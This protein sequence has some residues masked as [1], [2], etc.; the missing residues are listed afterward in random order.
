MEK[1]ACKINFEIKSQSPA[2]A[3][4]IEGFANKAI[5]DRGMDLIPPEAWEL[6]EFKNN[7]ILLFNHNQDLAIGT[8]DVKVTDNGLYAKAKISKSNEAPLPYIRDMIKEGIIKSFSVGFDSKNSEE[9]SEDGT[10]TVLKRANLLELSVVTVPMN[11][12]S[13]FMVSNKCVS[14][15]KS[16]SYHEA[17]SDML[18]FKGAFLAQA[19]HDQIAHLQEEKSDFD[20]DEVID[21]ILEQSG[22]SEKKLDEILAGNSKEIS[23][24][25][26]DAIAENLD[27]DPNQ[28]RSLDNGDSERKEAEGTEEKSEAESDKNHEQSE[29][30]SCDEDEDKEKMKEEEDE[31]KEKMMD[32][33]DKEDEEK[34]EHEDE[35]DEEKEKSFQE[36]VSDKI[37]KLIA[38]GKTQDQAIA[39]AISMC[40]DLEKSYEVTKKD[41]IEFMDVAKNAIPEKKNEEP[42]VN[43]D[44][45]SDMVEN[46][47]VSNP[48]MDQFKAQT[49]LMAQQNGLLQDL[50]NEVRALRSD[51]QNEKSEP[52]TVAMTEENPDEKESA[53]LDAKKERMSQYMQKLQELENLI[54]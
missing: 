27:L 1:K 4:T 8:A 2:R 46:A 38:E 7:N 13:T 20:R 29:K 34:M 53:E 16:K 42:T 41:Y 14:S 22:T 23:D 9:K 45:R 39:Q 51:L 33:E 24:S 40:Q 17:R 47:Q 43:L 44:A 54:N 30:Q 37:S 26:L 36:C 18:G 28:L 15:W 3:L 31:E 5:V 52:K 48:S 25:L 10:H 6:S 50:V 11:Q 32:D 49:T 19:V 35:E 12:E 21:R